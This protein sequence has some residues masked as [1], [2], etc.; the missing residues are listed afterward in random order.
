MKKY[1]KLSWNELFKYRGEPI[2]MEYTNGAN[3]LPACITWIS[4]NKMIVR[5]HKTDFTML[6]EN[7]GILYIC[8]G[9]E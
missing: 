2:F 6:K 5:W 8:I 1:K 3:L 7:Y 9:E 4:A